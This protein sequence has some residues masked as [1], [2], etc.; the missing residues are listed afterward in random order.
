MQT[1]ST[2]AEQTT[3]GFRFPRQ[4]AVVVLELEAVR[5]YWVAFARHSECGSLRCE[6]S[7]CWIISRHRLLALTK[8]YLVG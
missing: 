1:S 5:A 7:L 3:Q 2:P 4:W 6:I 8:A